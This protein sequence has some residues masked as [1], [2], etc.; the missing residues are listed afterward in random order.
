MGEVRITYQSTVSATALTVLVETNR[1]SELVR[2]H[3]DKDDPYHLKLFEFCVIYLE[4]DAAHDIVRINIS[5]L[6][7]L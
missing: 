2:K 5:S 3:N 1:W 4:F 7:T 6:W